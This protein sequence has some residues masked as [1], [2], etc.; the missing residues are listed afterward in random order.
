MKRLPRILPSVVLACSLSFPMLYNAPVQ[1]APRGVELAQAAPAPAPAPDK[2]ATPAPAAPATPAPAPGAETPPAPAAPAAPA[3]AA[4]AP[5]ATEPAAPAPEVGANQTLEQQVDDFW[6]YGEIGRYDLQAAYGNKLLQEGQQNPEQLLSLFEKVAAN[7]RAYPSQLPTDVD[8]ELL[9]WQAADPQMKTVATQLIDL[10]NKGRFAR[11]Q[12]PDYIKQ[13]IQRLNTGERGYMLGMQQLRNSGELAVPQMV[14]ILISN[15]PEDAQMHDVV[16]RGL[17]DLGRAALNPL[18]AATQMPPNNVALTSICGVLG[19]IGYPIAVPYLTALAQ[20]SQA[21][22]EVRSA[23]N[24]ALKQLNAD[25][26]ANAGDLFYDLANR[27]YLGTASVQPDPRQPV[28]FM[29]YWG[30]GGLTS[31]QLP[32]QI[33]NDLM[34]MRTAEQALRQ[35]P[36]QPDQSVSLWLA[37]NIRRSINLPQGATDPTRTAEEPQPHYYNVAEGAKYLN[38]VLARSLTDNTPQSPA[39]ALAAIKSLQDIVGQSNMFS[40][41]QGQPLVDALRYPDR[42]VRF[43]AAFAIASALP[44]RPFQGQA[45]VVPLLAEAVQQSGTPGVLI[46]ANPADRSR[47]T[48][49]LKGYQVAGGEDPSTAV[50]DSMTIPAVDVIII[51]EDMGGAAIDK[52]FELAAANPRL[53]R[54]AKLII[55]HSLA[56]PWARMSLTDPTLSYT[57]ATGGPQLAAAVEAARK[58]AGGLPMDEKVATD[59]ALRAAKLL[60]ELATTH[61]PVLDLSAAEQALI[62]SLGDKRAD[63]AKAVGNAVAMLDSKAAQSGLADRANDPN[64]PPDVRISLYKSLATSAKFYGNRLN[65]EQIGAIQQVVA[66]EK[67]LDIRSAAAEARGA[68]NLPSQDAKSLIVQRND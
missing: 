21:S 17:K 51:S 50:A 53:E 63:I 61:N 24:S 3:P 34:T 68:L 65:A 27:F 19:D 43:E 54:T 12:N 26:N 32:P 36:T 13:N 5:A 10:L 33:F 9:R 28:A 31:K 48:A 56:S 60:E 52:L 46:V 58:K 55:V 16:R 38:L 25:P 14:A 41:G 66:G 4:T 62:A 7:H 23:A 49:D 29:W 45:R 40:G 20:N 1:A 59:F 37:A 42:Q 64:T 30:D 18:L 2:D 22:N 44:Q 11:R 6:H 8:G 47:I 35:N 15:T 39:V 67:N 57:E